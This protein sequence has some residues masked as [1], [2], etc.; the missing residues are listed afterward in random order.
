MCFWKIFELRV[1][2][3]FK[4]RGDIEKTKLKHRCFRF[5]HC[6]FFLSPPLS[7][8]RSWWCGCDEHRGNAISTVAGRLEIKESWRC[9][10]LRELRFWFSYPVSACS[11]VFLSACPPPS[12]ELSLFCAKLKVRKSKS[13]KFCSIKMKFSDRSSIRSSWLPFKPL[14]T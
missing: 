3:V 6:I 1:P 8:Q 2:P 7:K 10:I 11:C 12:K 14:P 5:L 13:S 9:R 4:E